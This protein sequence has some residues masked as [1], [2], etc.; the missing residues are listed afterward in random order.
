MRKGRKAAIVIVI[1][2]LVGFLLFKLVA[3]RIVS[4]AAALPVREMDFSGLEDGT[5]TGSCEIFPV[6]VVV[7]TE[8]QN[9]KLTKIDLLEH[10][11][12]R[13]SA[14]EKIVDDILAGQSLQ[15]D[16]IAGAT[17]SSVAIRKAVED[18]LSGNEVRQSVAQ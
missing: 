17:V 10:F 18:A 11:N 1:V 6:R 8:V 2:L 9:G 13:G 7:Q 12:G 16:N 14:A 15:V 5:N 3:G 4:H